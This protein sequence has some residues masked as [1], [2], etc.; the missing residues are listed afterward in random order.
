MNINAAATTH[1]LLAATLERT[2]Q[3]VRMYYD[4]DREKALNLMRPLIV[5]GKPG[6]GKTVAI[7]ELARK[8]LKIGYKELRL[9]SMSEL[10]LAGLPMVKDNEEDGIAETTY[11]ASKL[12]PRESRDGEYGILALDEVTSC[13]RSA[14]AVALQL[15]DSSRG[16]G[17][18]KLP[19]KWI[20]VAL[21]NDSEDGG[22]FEGLEAA[23]INRCRAVRLEPDYASWEIWADAHGLNSTVKA[24]LKCYPQL[25]YVDPADG[26]TRIC[27][28]PRAWEGVATQ[29]D[30]SEALAGGRVDYRNVEMFVASIASDVTPDIAARLAAFYAYNSEM[31]DPESVLS[32]KAKLTGSDAG[33][34]ESIYLTIEASIALLI[35]RFRGV[36]AREMTAEHQ[37][38]VANYIKFIAQVQAAKGGEAAASGIEQLCRRVSQSVGLLGSKDFRAKYP[39]AYEVLVQTARKIQG[40]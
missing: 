24:F 15:L 18:Y 3:G 27:A 32:G 37:D 21:G 16:V 9:A 35:Q 31:I 12:L 40:I 39:A 14:R 29:L 34:Q 19:D 17:E 13:S 6:I 26:D 33:A 28:S 8:K 4:D 10:D 30:F 11:A 1:T 22:I 36:E 38:M 23:F 20:C 2:I 5:L 7:R 25:F